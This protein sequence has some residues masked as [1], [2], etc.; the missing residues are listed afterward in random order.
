M[1]FSHRRSAARRGGHV[2]VQVQQLGEVVDFVVHA[3]V[4]LDHDVELQPEVERKD[5]PGAAPSIAFEYLECSSEG[6]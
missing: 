4:A 3:V 2:E 6:K 5:P 1:E